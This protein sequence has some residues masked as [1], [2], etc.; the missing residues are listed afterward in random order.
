MI[1][2]FLTLLS[3]LNTDTKKNSDEVAGRFSRP[4]R[5]VERGA[6]MKTMQLPRD[7]PVH[8]NV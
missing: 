5:H 4:H 1:T 8:A 2:Y 6:L 3:Q 7:P